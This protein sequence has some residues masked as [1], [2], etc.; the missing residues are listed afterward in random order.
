MN[1][2][3]SILVMV[4]LGVERAEV[5]VARVPWPPSPDLGQKSREW[6]GR[7][8]KHKGELRGCI[9]E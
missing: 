7:W 4:P 9:W 3:D 5:R 2:E 6:G 1:S 8:L